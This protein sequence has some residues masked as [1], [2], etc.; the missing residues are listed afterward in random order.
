M[1]RI[2]RE[3][4]AERSVYDGKHVLVLYLGSLNNGYF[5]Q[6]CWVYLAQVG[7]ENLSVLVNIYSAMFFGNI[8]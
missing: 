6:K 5:V 2:W 1:W 3:F 7:E 4:K 8:G